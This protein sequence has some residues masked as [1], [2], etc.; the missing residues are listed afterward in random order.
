MEVLCPTLPRI[1]RDSDAGPMRLRRLLSQEW[2]ATTLDA[3]AR[4]SPPVLVIFYSS[5]FTLPPT[6]LNA[7]FIS[8]SPRLTFSTQ[9][10]RTTGIAN[11]SPLIYATR[12]FCGARR[13][14]RPMPFRTL[15]SRSLWAAR[16]SASSAA[17]HR[18]LAGEPT[19]LRPPSDR[20]VTG[21]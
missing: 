11:L 18:S 12:G 15:S 20:P 16:A 7:F 1:L 4:P 19:T 21:I 8:L 6:P 10:S 2:R 9:T 14:G 13:R 3:K 5:S 17:S